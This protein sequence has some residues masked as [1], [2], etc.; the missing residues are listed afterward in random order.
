MKTF[1]FKKSCLSSLPL[2]RIQSN[3]FELLFL[4]GKLLMTDIVERPTEEA[5]RETES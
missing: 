1:P 4:L 5:K 2:R 3:V